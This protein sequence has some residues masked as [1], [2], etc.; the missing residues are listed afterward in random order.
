MKRYIIFLLIQITTLSVHAANYAQDA[1]TYYNQKNYVAAI[2]AY[3]QLLSTDST[4]NITNPQQEATVYYNLGNCYYRVKDYANAVFAYQQTLRLAPSDKDA[5]F[6]LQLTQS[7]L[8]DQFDEPSKSLFYIFF[9]SIMLSNSATTWGYIALALFIIAS[10][11]FYFYKSKRIRIIYNKIGFFASIFSIVLT[12]VATTFAYVEH[13]YSY[14]TR[15]AV[16]MQATTAF[17]TPSATSKIVRELHSGVLI[18]ILTSQENGWQQVQLPDDN[19]CWINCSNL[20]IL[21]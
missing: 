19:T 13:N 4:L 10:I 14:P 5:Q 16:V 17:S 12:I 1:E 9:R 15:Q 11:C 2:H 20:A 8:Q 18:N 7:K 3:N 21:K 6:N